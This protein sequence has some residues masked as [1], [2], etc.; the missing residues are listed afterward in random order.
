[1]IDKELTKIVAKNSSDPVVQSIFMGFTLQ[2]Q[3]GLVLEIVRE[4]ILLSV[5][6]LL[7]KEKGFKLEDSHH[8]S[9]SPDLIEITINPKWLVAEAWD[10]T[11][12]LYRLAK[13]IY[14]EPR[15]TLLMTS[16]TG[17]S[18]EQGISEDENNRNPQ[19]E[20]DIKAAFDN[21][22]WHLDQMEV[23]QAWNL[24]KTDERKSQKKVEN[25]GEGIVIALP[26][27][28]FLP[29]PELDGVL[30]Y[31][32]GYDRQDSGKYLECNKSLL[33]VSDIIDRVSKS[34]DRNFPVNT[35]HGTATASLMVS[36]EDDA[37]PIGKNRANNYVT[38]VA[39][40]ATL[41]L[42]PL[43]PT[44][45][46]KFEFF[47]P[48]L[49]KAINDAAKENK[50]RIISI[51]FGG[52][53]TL[54][55]RRA[56][57]NAQR[58]GIIVVTSAG[59]GV[60]FA[61]WPSAYDSVISVA[62]SA[63]RNSTIA[64]H[65]AKSSRVDVAAPGEFVMVAVPE[66][67][68]SSQSHIY[69]VKPQSGTSYAA[70]LVAGVAALWLSYHGWETLANTYGVVRIPLVFD[71]LLRESCNPPPT[72]WDTDRWGAGIV[73]A[74]KLLSAKLPDQTDFY[75]QEPLAYRE[76]DHVRLDRG[77]VETFVHLF[78]QTL[79]D[80]A[81]LEGVGFQTI[82]DLKLGNLIKFD[83]FGNSYLAKEIKLD[84]A[85]WTLKKFL[86][87]ELSGKDFRQFL[88]TF[89]R[90]IAFHLGTDLTLHKRME[91]VLKRFAGLPVDSEDD[92]KSVLGALKEVAS[93]Y[94][95][96][97]LDKRGITDR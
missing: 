15:F 44:E 18:P 34:K 22:E 7:L 93:G 1:M 60:P 13:V 91:N 58:Q 63:F 5:A 81:F 86:S 68:Q 88:R 79:C 82:A 85:Q 77:G 6:E 17:G 35:W 87:L 64:K 48:S 52:Y 46:E 49:A 25:P 23:R 19:S 8:S 36:P 30:G 37:Q 21:P 12:K 65:S 73:N 70:P 59:N 72:G 56:I 2:I 33:S 9:L 31:T 74:Y 50:V 95:R 24:F 90:E 62:S 47:V 66:F 78:E 28:G 94:L 42:Y 97:T 3:D 16:G 76:V 38:G 39:P 54:A 10:L 61:V 29:H 67:D 20:R 69:T 45:L 71:K 41:H 57:I 43:G 4:E 14:A 92:L 83:N 96:E 27:T 75:I 32:V 40:G 51:S 80:P 53:P 89:G 55:L 26:D 84:I 11:H